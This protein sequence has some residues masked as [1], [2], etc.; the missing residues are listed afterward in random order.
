MLEHS[1]ANQD[2]TGVTSD[3]I[4]AAE[5]AAAEIQEEIRD[6]GEPELL[7]DIAYQD[8]RMQP[9]EWEGLPESGQMAV[10]VDHTEEL[11][12]DNELLHLV[13]SQ[14]T[15]HTFESFNQRNAEGIRGQLTV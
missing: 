12:N 5:T 14:W 13:G 11:P 9:D 7:E 15:L 8:N 3:V 2:P 1:I 6:D 10:Q 4:S